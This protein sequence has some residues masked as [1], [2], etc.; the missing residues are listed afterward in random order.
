MPWINEKD[1]ENRRTGRKERKGR[2]ETGKVVY[3]YLECGKSDPC[4]RGYLFIVSGHD[5]A[6]RLFCRGCGCVF[7]GTQSAAFCVYK[8]HS[9]MDCDMYRDCISDVKKEL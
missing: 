9:H 8:K 7:Y 3:K 4:D 1:E 5:N 6:D 2:N